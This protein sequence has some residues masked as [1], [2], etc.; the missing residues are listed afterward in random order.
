M[1]DSA[2]TSVGGNV[3]DG[4][5]FR[6][7]LKAAD[8]DSVRGAFKFGSNQHPVQ[9]IYVREVVKDGDGVTNKLVGKVFTNHSDAYASECAM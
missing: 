6:A 2:V 8:F 5:A 1:I 9:D 4:D 3:S 7:A